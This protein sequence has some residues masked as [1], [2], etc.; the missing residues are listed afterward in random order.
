MAGVGKLLKQ[1][2]KMQK[3]MEEVQSGLETEIV[4][5][6]S[7]GGAVVVNVNGHGALKSLKLDPEFLKEDA[8]TVESTIL[9]AINEAAVKAKALSDEKMSTVTGGFSLPGLF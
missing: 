6:S 5:V 7:G 9:S 2:Q 1:A 3:V 4:E 8:A